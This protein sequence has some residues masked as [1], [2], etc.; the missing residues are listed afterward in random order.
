VLDG[1][2]LTK[3][4]NRWCWLSSV[5][6]AACAIVICWCFDV[7]LVVSWRLINCF[8]SH[9]PHTS[10]PT[11]RFDD[12]IVWWLPFCPMIAFKI[13]VLFIVSIRLESCECECTCP[14]SCS[15]E[16][17][18]KGKLSILLD[19]KNWWPGIWD[20]KEF[21]YQ[22]TILTEDNNMTTELK[23]WETVANNL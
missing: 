6:V 5:S 7:V 2:Q 18:C 9:C 17:I 14:V 20:G 3:H 12:K 23:E 10:Y 13:P 11:P 22:G 16:C 21:K 4:A 1:E 19:V 8:T 15:G